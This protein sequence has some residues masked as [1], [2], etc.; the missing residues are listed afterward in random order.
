M[1]FAAQK[2]DHVNTYEYQQE[3]LFNVHSP[4]LWSNSTESLYQCRVAQ[5]RSALTDVASRDPAPPSD[6]ADHSD[7]SVP[8][9]R[10]PSLH[11]RPPQRRL[12]HPDRRAT[13]AGVAAVADDDALRCGPSP[14]KSWCSSPRTHANRPPGD[15]GDAADVCASNRCWTSC[16]C[17]ATYPSSLCGGI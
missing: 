6:A 2:L 17:A 11:H 3:K 7:S 8:G 12:C 1:S 15:D 13:G 14:T 5:T 16:G 10:P 9:E 4:T